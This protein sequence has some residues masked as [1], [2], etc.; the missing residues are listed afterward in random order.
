MACKALSQ[1]LL[2]LLLLLGA[3]IILKEGG[4]L[5][6]QGCGPIL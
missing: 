3:C 1:L 2:L 6:R 4:W 5:R